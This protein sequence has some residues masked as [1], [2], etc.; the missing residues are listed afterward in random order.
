MGEHDLKS[1]VQ[2]PIPDWT[3]VELVV[4]SVPVVVDPFVVVVV[5]P[6]VVVLVLGSLATILTSAQF[7]KS[8]QQE[9]SVNWI[10]CSH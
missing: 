8:K 6:T 1:M 9:L 2:Q 10:I 5:V 3:V 4:V 7:C